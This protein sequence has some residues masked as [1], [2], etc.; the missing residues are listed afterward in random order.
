[1]I[2][3][4]LFLFLLLTFTQK[5]TAQDWSQ[6]RGPARDGVVPA[7]STPTPWPK[8]LARLWRVELGEGYS[9]PVVSNGRAFVHSRQ[10][11]DELVSAINLAD[12]KVVW[13]QKYP[14]A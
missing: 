6:W 11:P 5:A 2:T 3:R 9:S 14:A 13:Q 7:L 12:G 10:D 1:M 8:S 4:Y